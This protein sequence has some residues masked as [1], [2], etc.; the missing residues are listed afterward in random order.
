MQHCADF[1][2]EELTTNEILTRKPIERCGNGIS[3]RF[4]PLFDTIEIV[5]QYMQQEELSF[6][7]LVDKPC[8]RSN[9]TTIIELLS[10]D[11]DRFSLYEEGCF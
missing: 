2:G 8:E 11:R 5:Q 4:V 3:I 9:D 1:N 7:I 6:A 10:F